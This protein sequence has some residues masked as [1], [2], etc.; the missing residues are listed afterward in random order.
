MTVGLALENLKWKRNRKTRNWM[1][2]NAKSAWYILNIFTYILYET[3]LYFFKQT[4][5][6]YFT[7]KFIVKSTD[8]I[9][10]KKAF[11]VLAENCDNYCLK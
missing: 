7:G 3:Y 11:K 8:C 10:Y 6:C 5:K 4:I 9:A 1:N 2:L